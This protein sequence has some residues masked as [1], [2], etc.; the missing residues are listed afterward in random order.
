MII[1]LK[2]HFLIWAN[3]TVSMAQPRSLCAVFKIKNKYAKCDEIHNNYTNI[4][5]CITDRFILFFKLITLIHQRYCA[6]LELCIHFGV[7]SSR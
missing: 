6:T 4:S 1:T 2:S 7:K 5:I 3:E